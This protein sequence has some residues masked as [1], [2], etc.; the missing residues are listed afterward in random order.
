M[1]NILLTGDSMG[2][3]EN[4]KLKLIDSGYNVIGLSRSSVD[5]MY[6]LSDVDCV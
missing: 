3:G 5:I 4:I 1:K 2:L 6:D